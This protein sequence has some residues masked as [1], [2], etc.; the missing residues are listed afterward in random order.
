MNLDNFFNEWIE[1]KDRTAVMDIYG[2]TGRMAIVDFIN[3]IKDKL[4]DNCNRE[5]DNRTPQNSSRAI[6]GRREYLPQN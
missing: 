4:D 1:E 3:F 6:N 5:S 2:L